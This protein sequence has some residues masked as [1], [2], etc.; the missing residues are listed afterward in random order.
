[1]NLSI[2]CNLR[3]NGSVAIS[4]PVSHY[5][6]VGLNV[7]LMKFNLKTAIYEADHHRLISRAEQEGEA[8]G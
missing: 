6:F 1:M 7:D 4:R 8:Q 3:L 2:F 5:L